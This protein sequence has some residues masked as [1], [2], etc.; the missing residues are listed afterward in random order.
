MYG[1]LENYPKT[2][3]LLNSL[4]K[5]SKI[6]EVR[7]MYERNLN[8]DDMFEHFSSPFSRMYEQNITLYAKSAPGDTTNNVVNY[9]ALKFFDACW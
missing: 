5:K 9:Q 7:D 8:D 4:L 3:L 2:L 6:N 1:G